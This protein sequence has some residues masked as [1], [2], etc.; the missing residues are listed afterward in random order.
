VGRRHAACSGIFL[1]TLVRFFRNAFEGLAIFF[2]TLEFTFRLATLLLITLNP[3]LSYRVA[4]WVRSLT[5]PFRDPLPVFFAIS[6]A[7]V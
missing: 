3:L 1:A 5:A 6:F 7:P 2:Y 4:V